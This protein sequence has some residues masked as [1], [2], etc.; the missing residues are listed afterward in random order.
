MRFSCKCDDK[1]V[2]YALVTVELENHVRNMYLLITAKT[3]TSLVKNL[4]N[5]CSDTVYELA[6]SVSDEEFE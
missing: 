3:Y 5:T 6:K 1:Y 2:I 4:L